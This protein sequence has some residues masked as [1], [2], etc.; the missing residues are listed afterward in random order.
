MN[1]WGISISQ[2]P[3]LINAMKIDVGNILLAQS[4]GG[5]RVSFNLEGA[6]PDLDRRIQ[7]PMYSQP[8]IRAW[9]V[10]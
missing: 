7:A 5:N 1:N 2:D 10:N 6:G 3:L 8:E 9:T 4:D